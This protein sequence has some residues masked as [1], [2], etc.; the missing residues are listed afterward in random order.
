MRTT[1]L[2]AGVLALGLL[3]TACGGEDKQAASRAG[4]ATLELASAKT[5]DAGTARMFMSIGVDTGTTPINFS[6]T[7]LTDLKSGASSLTMQLGQSGQAELVFIDQ[8]F[9]IK[10]PT[11]QLPP[12]KSWVQL[13]LA[14]I[15]KQRG[16]TANTLETLA[17]QDPT[18]ALDYL[19]GVSGEVTKV[20]REDVR[21]EPTT[22]YSTKI[23]VARAAA[24]AGTNNAAMQ[25]ALKDYKGTPFPVEIWVDDAGRMRKM[26]QAIPL[27]DK[28]E[29]GNL[30]LVIEMF[31]FGTPVDIKA[32]PA[33]QVADS[34][35]LG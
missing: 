18:K 1:R 7:G 9:Y 28:P 5:A 32:P 11:L 20:G 16:V 13:D 24:A 14:D 25:A 10:L 29:A 35:A 2:A 8:A 15:G 12:G 6:G 4:M 23:D 31:D 33:A 26:T 19:R 21:G 17:N 34:S 22:H 3:V 30:E 27:G